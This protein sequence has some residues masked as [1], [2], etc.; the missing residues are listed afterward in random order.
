MTKTVRR[1]KTEDDL[2]TRH[3]DKR[4]QKEKG[5]ELG[6]AV[7]DRGHPRH[8]QTG[9]YDFVMMQTIPGNPEGETDTPA[10]VRAVTP[11]FLHP[12]K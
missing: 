7:C 12:Y 8:S 1:V 4:G 5:E 6:G 9:K 3:T 11:E 10:S 2:C